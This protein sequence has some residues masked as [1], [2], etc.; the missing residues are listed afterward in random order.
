M[1]H[2]EILG[3]FNFPQVFVVEVRFDE[4]LMMVDVPDGCLVNGQDLNR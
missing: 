3:F 2:D 4:G 1:G